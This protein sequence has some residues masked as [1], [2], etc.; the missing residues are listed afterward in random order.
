[1]EKHILLSKV[2]NFG[3]RKICS[4]QNLVSTGHVKGLAVVF[5]LQT[6]TAKLQFWHKSQ[7]QLQNYGIFN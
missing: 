6:G 3:S 7:L 1:M 4:G 5:Q 2:L